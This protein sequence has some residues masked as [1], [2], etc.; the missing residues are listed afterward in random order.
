MEFNDAKFELI[1]YIVKSHEQL[2]QYKSSAGDDIKSYHTVKDLGVYM[3]DDCRFKTHIQSI[4]NK[5]R[6]MCAW[7]LRT[8]RTRD[9]KAMLI[10]WKTL[11]QPILDYSS[12]LWSPSRAGDIQKLESVPRAFTRQING[13]SGLDYWERLKTLNLMSQERRRDRYS[14]IYSWKIAELL[15][16]KPCS[17]LVPM[18]SGRRGREMKSPPINL[19]SSA[20]KRIISLRDES[21]CVKGPKLFNVMPQSIRN[22]TDCDVVSFK[23]QLDAFLKTVPDQ[24]LVPG[25]TSR[26]QF[27]SNSII[28]VVREIRRL[29]IDTV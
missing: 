2:H 21:F 6:S 1:R 20:S 16:P 9:K 19:K 22:I 29:P 15:V 3:D 25:Y 27:T 26:K 8:F 11:V 13:M 7:I 12:Q 14:V 5:S 4:I 18:N 28:D 23:R 10:L 24:P 17:E